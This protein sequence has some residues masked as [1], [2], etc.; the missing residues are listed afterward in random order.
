VSYPFG[1]YNT[2]TVELV[3]AA[4]YTSARGDLYSG[5]QTLARQYE[6][7]AMNAPTTLEEFKKKFPVR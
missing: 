1:Q 2:H 5:T 7:S 3:K 4:G 6:L